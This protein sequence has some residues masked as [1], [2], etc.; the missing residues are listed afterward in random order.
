MRVLVA[1][2]GVLV[3]GVERVGRRAARRSGRAASRTCSTS[4]PIRSRRTRARTS[5][6]RSRCATEDAASRSRPAKGASSRTRAKA[7][8]TYDGFVKGPAVGDVSRP[9]STSSTAGQWAIGI[10]FR[11]RFH[12]AAREDSSGCRTCSSERTRELRN[13][14]P[15]LSQSYL[16]RRRARRGGCLLHRARVSRIVTTTAR[17]RTFAGPLGALK[18]S[19]RSRRADTTRSSRSRPTRWARAA[20]TAT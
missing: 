3:A 4:P 5:S 1:T 18:L 8:A 11:Q 2:L 10:Q 19:V 7:R 16:A 17:T 20:S 15:F 6:T 12:E 14:A 13:H 9:S